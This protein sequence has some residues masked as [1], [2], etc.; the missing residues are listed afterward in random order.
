MQANVNSV[1]SSEASVEYYIVNIKS[2]F[3]Q[4]GYYF[5]LDKTSGMIRTNGKLD[6]EVTGSQVNLTVCAVNT[7]SNSP[8]ATLEEV[9]AS[10][11]SLVGLVVEL[12]LS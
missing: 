2:S 3:G 7:Q 11:N 1:L 9:S 12:F 6:R 10:I 8:Q 5:T 4:P